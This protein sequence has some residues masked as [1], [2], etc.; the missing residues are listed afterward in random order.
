VAARLELHDRRTDG[1]QGLAVGD[2]LVTQRIERAGHHARRRRAR[3]LAVER[4][5]ARIGAIGRRAGEVR[6]RY[7]SP[8]LAAGLA[9][10]GTRHIS[11]ASNQN[12]AVRPT[13]FATNPM[14][15]GPARMPS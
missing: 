3:E 9:S 13:A 8:Y 6:P 5:G 1:G 14:A 12:E 10:S 2:A 11:A 15:A 7:D 4:G